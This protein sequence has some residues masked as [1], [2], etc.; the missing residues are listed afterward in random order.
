MTKIITG[1]TAI[2]A[3]VALACLPT[4]SAQEPPKKPVPA[5]KPAPAPPPKPAVAPPPHPAPAARI[6]A[7]P[8]RPA[9]AAT[10]APA[11]VISPRV[12][13]PTGAATTS[14]ATTRSRATTTAAPAGAAVRVNSI[15]GA[16]RATI[17][18][19]NFSVRRDSYRVRRGDRWRTFVGPSALAAILFGAAYYYP[20]AYIDAS[21]EYCQGWTEDGCQLHWMAVPTYEGP[22]DFQCVAY[23][24]W[25]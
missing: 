6:V 1:L 19:Q 20:Y 8:A 16:N 13:S 14:G 4:A 17:G 22:T 5:A 24:P 12:V 15:R 11:H 2:L 3:V 25:Q 23:C 10:A 9:P 18:G 21:D 7:P